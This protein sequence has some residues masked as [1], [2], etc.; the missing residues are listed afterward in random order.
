MSR[1]SLDSIFLLLASNIVLHVVNYNKGHYE[2]LAMIGSWFLALLV[3]ES[4]KT[5]FFF[6]FINL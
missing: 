1:K 2:H 5:K 4:I 3:F 6:S